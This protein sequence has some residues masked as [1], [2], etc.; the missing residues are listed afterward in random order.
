LKTGKLDFV[1]DANEKK[2]AENYC[3]MRI[4]DL[5][6]SKEGEERWPQLRK[7]E[8]DRIYEM[9]RIIDLINKDAVVDTPDHRVAQVYAMFQ[10]FAEKE[11][12]LKDRNVVGK[13]WPPEQFFG[14]LDCCRNLYKGRIFT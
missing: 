12:K 5:I 9:E 1:L 8:T 3:F 10:L 4:F 2:N 14:F 6:T 11:I 13:S 7:H